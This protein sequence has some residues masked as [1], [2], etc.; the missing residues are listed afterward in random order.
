MTIPTGSS[1]WVRGIRRP[2]RSVL[3]AAAL[4]TGALLAVASPPARAQSSGSLEGRIKSQK[5][6]LKEIEEEIKQHRA[7]SSELR[8][9][10]T[11]VVKQLSYLDKE[12]AL[13]TKYLSGLQKKE[14]LLIQQIDSLR[15]N[16]SVESN[17]LARQKERLAARLRQMYMQGPEHQ[18]VFVMGGENMA[19]KLRRYKFTRMLAEYDAGLVREVGDRKLGL[20]VE[21]AGVAEALS[22][23]AALKKVQESETE[24]LKKNK[25]TRVAMLKRIRKDDA[26]HKQAI[27]DLEKSQERLK[28]LIGELERKRV[29]EKEPTGLPPGGFASLKGKLSRP[30]DGQVIG[31]FGQSKHPRFGTVTINNGVD[32]QARAGAPIRSVAAGRVEFVDWIEGYGNCIILNHGGGYYTLYAH[33]SEIFV[34]TDENVSANTV[35]AEVGDSGSLNGY[36]CHFEVRKSKQAL[37]PM[38]W[39]A[40]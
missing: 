4:F 13:S 22:E 23:I 30:V 35:I 31:T 20:E 18:W 11:D 37:N 1:K 36:A 2:R 28:D 7:K 32:I 21:Q 39:F 17:V 25:T 6:R 19:E 33:A 8:K 24:R 5:T 9:K 34:R 26:G 15:T 3:L 10:E 40:K 14:T 27:T 38:E 12:I 16:I 29:G